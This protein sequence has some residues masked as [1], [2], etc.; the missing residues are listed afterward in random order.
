MCSSNLADDQRRNFQLADIIPSPSVDFKEDYVSQY[1]LKSRFDQL[2]SILSYLEEFIKE[3]SLPAIHDHQELQQKFNSEM[4]KSKQQIQFLNQQNALLKAQLEDMDKLSQKKHLVPQAKKAKIKRQRYIQEKSK[5]KLWENR[6][7]S[8]KQ[9]NRADSAELKLDLP[10]PGTELTQETRILTSENMDSDQKFEVYSNFDKGQGIRSSWS[11]SQKGLAMGVNKEQ[12]EQENN[13]VIYMN[14]DESSDSLKSL[15]LPGLPD[16]PIVRKTAEKSSSRRLGFDIKRNNGYDKQALNSIDSCMDRR[17]VLQTVKRTHHELLHNSKKLTE[18][19]GSNFKCRATDPEVKVGQWERGHGKA[20][21]NFNESIISLNT[22]EAKVIESIDDGKGARKKHDESFSSPMQKGYLTIWKLSDISDK[23][24]SDFGREFY[25]CLDVLP[26]SINRN[27]IETSRIKLGVED[28]WKPCIFWFQNKDKWKKFVKE[29]RGMPL[30]SEE[31]QIIF[32]DL[33]C[34][35]IFLSPESLVYTK[36][37]SIS[38]D[39]ETH[40]SIVPTH[41]IKQKGTLDFFFVVTNAMDNPNN[42]YKFR[43]KSKKDKEE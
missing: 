26:N 10:Q 38:Q 17:S 24:T 16:M 6:F 35:K 31:F 22:K 15:T 14:G 4:M 27:A 30:Q 8:W 43:A 28:E 41:L 5:P 2:A 25:V 11:Q 21:K 32:S 36:N 34:G 42:L 9:L 37:D 13:G 19:Y 3:T 7:M 1:Q 33:S 12:D 18:G 40:K 23:I 29:T 39:L 20:N